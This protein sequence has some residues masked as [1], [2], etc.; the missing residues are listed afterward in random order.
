MYMSNTN[1]SN[2][3]NQEN[4]FN[5]PANWKFGLFY[6]NKNDKRIF[7][8]RKFSGFGWTINFANPLSILAFVGLFVIIFLITKL[9]K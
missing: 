3:D 6:F 1:N 5:D 9:R 7:P 4:G 8:P 2:T